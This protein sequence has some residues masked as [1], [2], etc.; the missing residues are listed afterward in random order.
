ME[1][2]VPIDSHFHKEG[3]LSAMANHNE[4]AK[5]IHKLNAKWWHDADGNRLDRNRGELLMLVVSELSEAMEA[6]RKDLNDDK[7]PHR[8]GEE[9]E[10]A[11]AYIRLMDYASGFDIRLDTWLIDRRCKTGIDNRAENLFEI[12][13]FVTDIWYG[14]ISKDDK[15]SIVLSSIRDYAHQYNLDLDGAIAEKLEYN[16]TREDHTHAH[17]AGVG[18]KKF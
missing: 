15:V 8:K 3:L 14:E 5:E 17:R 10:L 11:D 7:L 1:N 12:V 4:Q 16:K 13:R 6:L 9:V 2:S 18:G